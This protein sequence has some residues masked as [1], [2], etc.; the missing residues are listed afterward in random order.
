MIAR[1]MALAGIALAALSLSAAPVVTNG[2]FAQAQATRA[3]APEAWDLPADSGWAYVNDDGAS[4]A[5]S[6]RFR[7]TAQGA[8]KALAQAVTLTPNAAYVLSASFK[9]D[10]RLR[11]LVLLRAPGADGAELA[12]LECEAKAPAGTWQARTQAFTAG[13][14]TQAVVELWADA[15]HLDGAAPAGSAGIDDVQILTAAEA[16]AA[17]ATPAVP[18]PEN[19][20]RGC[21]YT[22][23]PHPSYGLC[24]DPDDKIQLTDGV[25]T[26]GYFWTQKSTVGWSRAR[27]VMI[28]LDLGA[29]VPISGLSFNTAAGVAGVEFP[30]AIMAMVSV[31]GR[32]YYSLGDM[33]S[34][35]RRKGIPP[36]E[37]YAVHRYVVD[38]LQTH[39]RYVKLLIDTAGAYCFVDE[40]E[41]FRGQ[42]EWTQAALTGEAIRYP[43]EYFQDNL[44]NAA[45]KRRIGY[46]LEAARTF[47]LGA[48]LDAALQTR[49]EAE[50]AAIET[51]IGALPELYPDGYRSVVPLNDLHA[52]VY[53]LY[54]AVR[55][56]RGLPTLIAWGANPWDFL[57]PADLPDA[58]PAP[59]ISIAA[60]RGEH[61]A[62][63][64]NLTNNGPRPLQ[65]RLSLSG[66]PGAPVPADLTVHEIPWTDTH[67]GTLIAAALPVLQPVG[68]AFEVTVPAGM[69]RQVYVTFQPKQTPAGTHLGRIQISAP[70]LAPVQ[71]PLTLRV[72]DLDFPAQPRLH[73]GGWDYTDVD[74]QY[75]VTPQNRDAL[76]AHLRERYVDSP[77]GTGS[78]MPIGTF[79]PDAAYTQPPDTSRFERWLERWPNARRYCVFNAIG[80][81]IAG[82]P[83]DDPGFAPRVSTWIRF[84]AD[85]VRQKGLRTDQLVLLLLDEPNRPEQDRIIVAWA[86]VIQA[87]EPDVV[88]W[89][90]PTHRDPTTA[91]P[92]MMASV[93]VLCPNRPMLL[94]GGK[95]FA[96]FYRAQKAAG[97][98]LDFYSCSGPAFLLDPYSYHRLQA[99]TAFEFGAESSYFWAF[100]D[101]GGGDPWN[102]YTA[103]RTAYAP[104]FVAPSSV[105]AGKHM[106]AIR[107]SVGDFEILAMLRDRVDALARTA[108]QDARLERARALLAAAPARVLGAEGVDDLTW[109]DPK[110]RG[111][112]D[113]VRIEV[114]EMLEALK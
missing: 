103:K 71:V 80:G 6:V 88:L 39:G 34:L 35:S 93:D 89:E 105:T 42:P 97:R 67:E 96:D 98:R 22:L 85:F 92:E 112:A 69:T 2:T 54:G 70:G 9:T 37:K 78:V 65:L 81:A 5:L 100:A 30:R 63:A 27:P 18:A 107:E 38:D 109:S 57:R 48:G 110:D 50:I 52:R 46:D 104:A 87:V 20:A 53:A 14:A 60:M 114:A 91:L 4:D 75:G 25:Y 74:A 56:A 16:A 41:V 8:G 101:T 95:P 77:W 32:T 11:P 106:E 68:E 82:V 15:R 94:Q 36:A 111:I 3:A 43:L 102:A 21:A 45:V 76:I 55:S 28:T 73:V 79:G 62:G 17:A 59:A 64:V 83:M 29:D 7:A 24:T 61:R 72:F 31:D 10:G 99:W 86:Q 108:P 26:V 49:L 58:P 12:R 47:V 90:D 1:W 66:L 44:F 33:V 23:E 19:L 40:I 113:T 84:W 51:G 13:A